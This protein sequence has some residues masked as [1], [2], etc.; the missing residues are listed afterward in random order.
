MSVPGAH[1]ASAQIIQRMMTENQQRAARLEN[2]SAK[3]RYHLKYTG[4]PHTLEASMDVE[5]TC[6]APGAK[7][8]RIV[9]ESGSKLLRERVLQKLLESEEEALKDPARSALTTANY[10]FDLVATEGDAATPTYVF[11]VDPKHDSKFLYRG[12][13][14][15]DG[16]DFAV[17]RVQAE[18]AKNPSF[19]ISK[20]AI[21][22]TYI[23]IGQFWL[24]HH[25]QS[26][27]KVRFGGVA[28]LTIDYSGFHL[29]SPGDSPPVAA[30]D[31][32]ASR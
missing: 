22:H 30:P 18:P 7:S 26:D 13:I 5:V 15:V 27:T 8:F 24:P 17:K 25:N 14:W 16:A 3:R 10:N 28:A 2:Y 19:W 21:A 1:L 29:N 20:T 11:Q 9:S 6:G 32:T 4:F 31:T 23:K 12:T